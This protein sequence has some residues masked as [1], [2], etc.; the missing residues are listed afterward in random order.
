M[1]SL[2]SEIPSNGV[3]TDSQR[4]HNGVTTDPELSQIAKK[5]DYEIFRFLIISGLR[6]CPSEKNRLFYANGGIVMLKYFVICWATIPCWAYDAQTCGRR[7]SPN[8]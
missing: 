6:N 7:V 4:S 8:E 3:A 1:Y 5:Q 2:L